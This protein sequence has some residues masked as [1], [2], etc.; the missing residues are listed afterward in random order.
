[1]LDD[2]VH[3]GAKP[4]GLSVVKAS[5]NSILASRQ[6]GYLTGESKHEQP[7]QIRIPRSPDSL[8]PRDSGVSSCA[9]MGNL[10]A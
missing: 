5:A 8:W 1:M 2:L 7:A 6:K 4:G 3:S 10:L 9:H